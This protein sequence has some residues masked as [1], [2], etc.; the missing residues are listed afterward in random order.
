MVASVA[1]TLEALMP[2]VPADNSNLEPVIVKAPETLIA[3][4][5][6][7]MTTSLPPPEMFRLPLICMAWASGELV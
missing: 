1:V 7:E 2:Y 4:L 5:F 6:A 3:A